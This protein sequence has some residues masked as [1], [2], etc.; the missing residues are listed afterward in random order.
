MEQDFCIGKRIRLTA[1][2]AEPAERKYRFEKLSAL[3]ELGGK[4]KRNLPGF[5]MLRTGAVY[6]CWRIIVRHELAK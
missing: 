6:G 3:C 1:E 2:N 4:I 5:R